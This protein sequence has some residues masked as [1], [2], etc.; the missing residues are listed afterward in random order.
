MR[1]VGCVIGDGRIACVIY[2]AKSTDDRRGSIPGQL[3]EC[4]EAAESAGGRMIVGEYSDEAFSAFVG[5]RGG[6][7]RGDAACPGAPARRPRRAV[8]AAQ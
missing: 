1:S 3:L 2:A 4:R 7:C 8:G 5:S 6:A